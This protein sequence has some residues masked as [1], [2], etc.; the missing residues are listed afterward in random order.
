M[1]KNWFLFRQENGK[2]VAISSLSKRPGWK[3]HGG[4]QRITLAPYSFCRSLS[5]VYRLSGNNY[6]NNMDAVGE[7]EP[8]PIKLTSLKNNRVFTVPQN[9]RVGKRQPSQLAAGFNK[10]SKVLPLHAYSDTNATWPPFAMAH[11]EYRP[12]MPLKVPLWFH[13]RSLP[14]SLAVYVILWFLDKP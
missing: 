2:L 7:E 10:A 1:R 8:E 3:Q 6:N 12:V 11:L 5:C 9:D 4:A 14:I 13:R